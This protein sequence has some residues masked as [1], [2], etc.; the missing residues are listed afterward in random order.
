V[1]GVPDVGPL[2]GIVICH[3]QGTRRD[4]N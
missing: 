1:T 4:S 3:G 2:A